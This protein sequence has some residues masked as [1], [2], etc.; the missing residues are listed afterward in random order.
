MS[1]RD[2][3]RLHEALHV[4]P[5]S[6]ATIYTQHCKGRLPWLTRVGPHGHR[7]RELWINVP[8]A[9]QWWRID[10]KPHVAHLLHEIAGGGA[11]G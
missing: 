11:R 6:L 7:T 5:L 2:Q 4:L 1:N 9:V 10:G 8:T 3:I